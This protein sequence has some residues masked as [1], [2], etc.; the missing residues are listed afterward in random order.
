[1]VSDVDLLSSPCQPPIYCRCA[2]RFIVCKRD[3]ALL[4][5]TAPSSETPRPPQANDQPHLEEEQG[6]QAR[7]GRP[8]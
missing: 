3:R 7:P 5:E 6:S 1:M 8:W 4:K 2:D